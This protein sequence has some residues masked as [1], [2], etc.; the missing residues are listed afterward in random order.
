MAEITP[1]TL[2]GLH[3]LLRRELV[4]LI[5]IPIHDGGKIDEPFG[6]LEC[7]SCQ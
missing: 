3:E 6:P 1:P 5:G 2:A 4:A 7:R